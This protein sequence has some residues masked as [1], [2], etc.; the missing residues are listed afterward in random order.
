MKIWI[1]EM[2]FQPELEN[3]MKIIHYTVFNNQIN[4]P[5]VAYIRKIS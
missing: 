1:E 3:I 4:L 2:I 5:N